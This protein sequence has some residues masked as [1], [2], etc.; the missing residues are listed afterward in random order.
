MAE[1]YWVIGNTTNVGKTTVAS[2]LVRVLND[3][4][5]KT[6]GFKPVGGIYL[7]ES[8]DFIIDNYK[9]SDCTIYGNDSVKLSDASPISNDKLLELIS[10]VYY[11]MFPRFPSFIMARTGSK[12]LNNITFYKTDLMDSLRQRHDIKFIIDQASLPINAAKLIKNAPF[13]R[14]DKIISKKTSKSYK[15]LVNLGAEAVVIEGAGRFIPIWKNNPTLNHLF[16]IADG[17]LIFFPNLNKE[18][19]IDIPAA[20]SRDLLRYIGANEC[21]KYVEP[22]Y[23]SQSKKINQNTEAIVKSLLKHK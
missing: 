22:L 17:F 9:N 3:R 16:L 20:D 18:V 19:F 21:R 15:Y 1:N 2:A 6:V 12:I 4:G 23:V 14:N 7:Y 11:L 13:D 5:Q 8:V 10:P